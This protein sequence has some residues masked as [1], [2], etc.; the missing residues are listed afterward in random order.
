M[1]AAM[2]DAKATPALPMDE[3]LAKIRRIIAEDE[4]AAAHTAAEPGLAEAPAAPAAETGSDKPGD[5]DDVLELTAAIDDDG[6]VTQ[7]PPRRR[8]AQPPPVAPG[9]V[10]PPPT[11]D[12]PV[13]E[14]RLVAPAPILQPEAEN[15]PAERRE[16]RLGEMRPLAARTLDDIVCELLRPLLRSWIDDNLPPLVE[17]LTREELARRV[18]KSGAA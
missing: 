2:S 5:D 8:T 14:P 3:I 17:R 6:N 1:V 15:S 7:L 16:P 13:A 18:E 12:T 10:A 9:P 11:P 4:E